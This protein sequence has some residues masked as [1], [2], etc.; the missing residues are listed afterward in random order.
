M[1]CVGSQYIMRGINQKYNMQLP[2]RKPG[3]YSEF[4]TD[5]VMT[6]GKFDEL[7]IELEN[8]LQKRPK[9]AEEVGRLAELGDF[10]ENV[11]YQLAKRRLRGINSAIL[12]IDYQINHADIIEGDNKGVVGLGSV[13]TIETSKGKKIYTILG[14]SETNPNKGIISYQSPLGSALIGHR[15]G[16]IIEIEKIGECKLVSIDFF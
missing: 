9:A 4:P 5:H 2:K 10:S 6:Q 12:K 14:A 3:K 1:K 13:V 7:V 16:D 11:E 8:L 15:V